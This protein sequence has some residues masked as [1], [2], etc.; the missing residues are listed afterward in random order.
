MY[1]SLIL[2]ILFYTS[3]FWVEYIFAIFQVPLLKSYKQANIIIICPN[4]INH[5]IDGDL[6]CYVFNKT[7]Y[8]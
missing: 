3:I 4:D 1:I 8:I 5:A 2:F 6:L 7:K